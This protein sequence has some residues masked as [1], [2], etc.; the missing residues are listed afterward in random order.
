M[1]I[2]LMETLDLADI[3]RERNPFQKH[4]TWSSN[5]SPDIHCRLDFFLIF[6][7]LVS[8]VTRNF[9]SPSLQSDH[10]IISLDIT[11][12][13]GRRG[14]SFWKFNCSFP[15]D[16]NYTLLIQDIIVAINSTEQFLNASKKWEF[17]KFKVGM[18]SMNYS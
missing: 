14:P 5:V 1:R 11:I 15:A 9:F 17:I 18:V 10:F 13:A 4:F 2:E 6:R 8:Q 7:N 16:E 12:F 3:W